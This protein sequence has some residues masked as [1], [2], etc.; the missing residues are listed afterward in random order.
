MDK[1]GASCSDYALS[2]CTR[3]GGY[4]PNSFS[5]YGDFMNFVD[6]NTNRSA[7]GACCAC[8]ANR[9]IVGCVT[10]EVYITTLVDPGGYQW[11]IAESRDINAVHNGNYMANRRYLEPV[12]LLPG[13][14]TFVGMSGSEV[15]GIVE[16]AWG[17]LTL[18]S[19][20]EMYGRT[21]L[22]F[23]VP[24]GSGACYEGA[25]SSCPLHSHCI[26]TVDSHYCRCEPGYQM[27]GGSCQD[28]DECAQDT[29]ECAADLLCINT[30]GFY[31]CICVPGTSCPDNPNNSSICE[32]VVDCDPNAVCVDQGSWYECACKDP[33][34]GD[35]YHCYDPCGE[36]Q[37]PCGNNSV[38]Y[39]FN[40][41][42]YEC[43][44]A[45]GYFDS[46]HGCEDVD[47]CAAHSS[48]LCEDDHADCINTDGGY[49]CK[50]QDGYFGYS[51]QAYPSRCV[52]LNRDVPDCVTI[53]VWVSRGTSGRHFK[54]NISDAAPPIQVDSSSYKS[55][56]GVLF[57]T[58]VCLA[59]G[60]YFYLNGFFDDSAGSDFPGDVFY[61]VTYGEFELLP[62]QS[63]FLF[64]AF[65]LPIG[66]GFCQQNTSQCGLHEVCLDNISSAECICSLGYQRNAAG[67]CTG[68][69]T[70]EVRVLTDLWP[71]QMSWTIV[72]STG[73]AVVQ[74]PAG[75]LRIPRWEYLFTECLP[76]GSYRFFASDSYGDG[77]TTGSFHVDIGAQPLVPRTPVPGYEASVPFTI[78]FTSGFCGEN[79]TLK[80]CI[81]TQESCVDTDMG[82][83]C[84]CRP[85]LEFDNAG[86]CVD[87]DECALGTHLCDPNALCTN[88]MGYF[89]CTCRNGTAGDGIVCHG[90][91]R[92]TA[93][94]TSL[95]VAVESG[96]APEAVGWRIVEAFPEVGAA[97]GRLHQPENV[98]TY[99]VCL[100]PGQ[101]TFDAATTVSKGWAAPS[102]MVQ[103]G[104]KTLVQSTEIQAFWFGT[105]FTVPEDVNECLAQSDTCNRNAI[106]THEAGSYSCACRDGFVGN[107][108]S[109]NGPDDYASC[110]DEPAWADANGY[111][112]DDYVRNGWC[113]NWWY[114]PVWNYDWGAFQDFSAVGR[115]GADRSCCACGRAR[116]PVQSADCVVR[117]WSPWGDC[118]AVNDSACQTSRQR[119]IATLP[120]MHGRPCPALVETK[121]CDTCARCMVSAWEDW[122][123]YVVGEKFRFR[124]VLS[125]PAGSLCGDLGERKGDASCTATNSDSVPSGFVAQTFGRNQYGQLGLGDTITRVFADTALPHLMGFLVQNGDLGE[126]HSAAVAGWLLFT[127]GRNDYGQL[128]L[129]DRTLRTEP[130][131]VTGLNS[132]KID[133]VALG[134][135]HTVVLSLYGD[136]YTF[137]RNDYGQLGRTGN[138]RI[139]IRI[140]LPGIY[141]ALSIAAGRLHTAIIAKNGFVYVC[142]FNRDGR[143]GVGLSANNQ[144]QAVPSLT[145]VAALSSF[146]VT[147]VALGDTHTLFLTSTRQLYASGD[148]QYSQAG[149]EE[150]DTPHLVMSSPHIARIAAG[151]FH[152]AVLMDTGELYTFGRNDLGQLGYSTGNRTTSSTPRLMATDALSVALGSFH[153][154]Y[155]SSI[156]FELMM[157]GSNEQ[158]QLGLGPHITKSAPTPLSSPFGGFI[159]AFALG[160]YHTALIRDSTLTPTPTGSATATPTPTT[161][162]TLTPTPTPISTLCDKSQ[163]GKSIANSKVA[164]SAS[165]SCVQDLHLGVSSDNWQSC[166]LVVDIVRLSGTFSVRLTE[167]CISGCSHTYTSAHQGT[168]QRIALPSGSALGVVASFT[169]GS[170]ASQRRRERAA[171]TSTGVVNISVERT[172]TSSLLV[173]ST[174]CCAVGILVLEL[175][176]LG[177]YHRWTRSSRTATWKVNPRMQQFWPRF[178]TCLGA[179]LLLC[180]ICFFIIVAATSQP[181]SPMALVGVASAA[182]G[183]GCVLLGICAFWVLRD[184]R[185]HQCYGCKKRMTKWRFVG[186]YLPPLQE[187]SDVPRR[188][189]SHCVRCVKCHKRAIS[190][191]W[192]EAPHNR[193]YHARCWDLHCSEAVS[194]VTYTSQWLSQHSQVVTEIELA[195]M[196]AVA[197]HHSALSV[198]Q[199]LLQANPQLPSVPIV[200]E[201]GSNTLRLAAR[202]GNLP[203]LLLL[204]QTA[205][206]CLDPNCQVDPNGPQSLVIRGL[207]EA[208]DVYILQPFLTYN[209]RPIYVGNDHGRYIY[210]YDP[211]EDSGKELHDPGWCLSCHLGSGSAPLR[212][213]LPDPMRGEGKATMKAQAKEAAQ[214][215][216]HKWQKMLALRPFT[217]W[218]HTTSTRAQE[219]GDAPSSPL[220]NSLAFQETRPSVTVQDLHM[221]WIPHTVSLMEE[222]IA[223]GNHTTIQHVKRL[224]QTQDPSCLI[225][226]WH[227]GHGLWH[228]FSPA[229]QGAIRAAMAEGMTK[230]MLATGRHAN[231]PATID[232]Q[233]MRMSAKRGNVNLKTSMR[234]IFQY[235]DS[236]TDTWVVT[237]NAL[238]IPNWQKAVVVF[239]SSQGASAA[240]DMDT[241]AFLC[242]EGVVDYSLWSLPSKVG[243]RVPQVQS[244]RCKQMFREVF[245]REVTTVMGLNLT[246]N[247]PAVAG[248]NRRR[249][250]D[251]S[252]RVDTGIGSRLTDGLEAPQSNQGVSFYPANYHN[253]KGCLPYCA[254]LPDNVVGYVFELE[255]I[256]EMS[257]DTLMKVHE[258]QRQLT[259]ISPRD[260]VAVFVYTYELS[261]KLEG[262][263]QI[264]GAM[265]RAMRLRE[266]DKIE[267]WRPLIW[268]I[269]VALTAF[270]P[271][272][273]KCYR[274][275]NCKM[276]AN[277][278]QTGT[279]IC[280]PSFS[281]AS[282]NLSVAEVFAKGDQG[283]LFFLSSTGARPI[284]AVSRFPEEAEVLFP[285]NTVFIITSTLNSQSEIGA[286]YGRIDNVAMTQC[287]L[288]VAPVMSSAQDRPVLVGYTSYVLHIPMEVS[289]EMLD[290]LA[291]AGVQVLET[292]EPQ[293]GLDHIAAEL[294]MV[295]THHA[296]PEESWPSDMFSMANDMYN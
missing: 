109:C 11:Y 247:I 153:S 42:N 130:K 133:R 276:D 243:S 3:G 10:I 44:C 167:G 262:H 180:G 2:L 250:D 124:T 232:F 215:T 58:P 158:G 197:V 194:N 45:D 16:M 221:E 264:Y 88:V 141:K 270:P 67:I 13:N 145:L 271:Y 86:N 236:M 202:T 84:A 92:D 220:N 219:V 80:P 74:R 138:A 120:L 175:L 19:K 104:E 96:D 200:Q 285:S 230:C 254:E 17:N 165:D 237:S 289:G 149:T 224:Y 182:V 78:P 287:G 116:I 162:P 160:G 253:D 128:G 125:T 150:S 213:P 257:A 212:L 266:M 261:S 72:A 57:M 76:G 115:T 20:T 139:P 218:E 244:E 23:L 39:N 108:I 196:L 210:F 274:G 62:W 187:G 18:M 134:G 136:V 154:A 275:I 113:E 119:A 222:S 148:N 204:L 293:D 174:V 33:F 35:G 79:P 15:S 169:S 97:V 269:D 173:I 242:S 228:T 95:V 46:G 131:L 89:L 241:L 164:L 47:E 55:G 24:L 34:I 87:I 126:E 238:S 156:R 177:L 191:A 189:H 151:A 102:F 277:A 207:P 129:G 282:Q 178:C 146:N 206:C 60:S 211:A 248:P 205:P 179:W 56:H 192:P 21:E 252:Y 281:S 208:N 184:T 203:V 106:C 30:D 81:D 22:P 199:L 100:A 255:A 8:G 195:H 157:F 259:C 258:M 235:M 273:G 121:P 90:P 217:K 7:F 94:C 31:R 71:D 268:E 132:L 103:F 114:G 123:C 278:Y 171:T 246:V 176:L 190:D 166:T 135:F 14:Y 188:A 292:M 227:T 69:T 6:P 163:S 65:W 286:F 155:L 193:P 214:K 1:D 75:S 12:C 25:S 186:V 64:Q 52:A 29:D 51:N 9:D 198:I 85:G 38:C 161:P 66:P 101:Y 290:R 245:R 27:V 140:N 99:Q 5:T 83:V 37:D 73:E 122:G 170:S 283:T 4:A 61:R 185:R 91:N 181:L 288:E 272:K 105:P 267:F 172:A 295:P 284:S 77:W 82:Y 263:D 280:W 53:A 294:V 50:C 147:Q 249:S 240:P 260:I 144:L 127:W 233:A 26:D 291:D 143:L 239:S 234:S 216:H 40:S 229:T 32:N 63:L 117:E 98:Y 231:D 296:A 118:A 223:S 107:G 142:G 225:W 201:K 110:V 41:T 168:Q 49:Y 28:V 93:N 152:N 68:C 112:C 111:T 183:M 209:D 48:L 159:H 70:F 256:V 54:W 265:N 59:P 279:H 251:R 36:V 226:K 137:G 43:E